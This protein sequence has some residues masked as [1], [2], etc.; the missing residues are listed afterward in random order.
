MKASPARS[1]VFLAILGI[2]FSLMPRPEVALAASVIS[3]IRANNITATSATITWQ[4][5]VPST[6]QV[7]RVGNLYEPLG[8]YP[9]PYNPQLVTQH[10]VVMPNLKPNSDYLFYVVSKDAAGTI[11]SS[12]RVRPGLIATEPDSISTF[13]TLAINTA[14]ALDYRLDI[15]GPKNVYA[16]SDLY[17]RIETVTT[18]G[19][20][21]NPVVHFFPAKQVSGLPATI[22]YTV[23]CGNFLDINTEPAG[24][25]SL[26]C[27]SS[28]NDAST[29]RFKVSANTPPGTYTAQVKTAAVASTSAT[30]PSLKEV[31]FTYTFN[32]LPAPAA[33]AKTAI[34]S[35]PPIPG[36]AKWE[37]QMLTLGQ[38]WCQFNDIYGVSYEGDV[39]Y[40][41]GGRVY[42]QIADY[43]KDYNK[44]IPCAEQVLLQYR[45]NILG[46]DMP[47]GWRRFPF[48]L[49]MHY[50]RYGDQKDKDALMAL[51]KL[52]DSP[53]LNSVRTSSGFLVY[54]YY[55]RELSYAIDILVAGEQVGF[56]PSQF[57]GRAVD[58]ALAMYDQLFVSDKYKFHH[59]FMDG[60]MAEALISYYE[61]TKDPRIPP[62]IKQ[63]L[64]WNWNSAWDQQLYRMPY[65]YVHVPPE[66]DNTLNNLIVPAYAWYWQLTGDDT[67]RVRG[68]EIFLHALD[69]D[70]S[71]TGKVFSQ[72]YKWSFDYVRWRSGNKL[73]AIQPAA[74]P[75]MAPISPPVGVPPAVVMYSGSPTAGSTVS[76]NAVTVAA[77]AFDL[78]GIAEVKF[79]ANA[80]LI[81]ASSLNVWPYSVSWNTTAL[82]NG[83][84]NVYAVAKDT[85]GN[86][87]NSS[88]VTVQVN[89][90]GAPT[91]Q[92][93]TFPPAVSG[94]STSVTSS[95]AVISWV[96]N[97]PSDSQVEYGQS[98]SYGITS[99]LGDTGSSMTTNHS[100]ILPSLLSGVTYYFRIKSRDQIGN[101]AVSSQQVF[102][103]TAASSSVPVP[104]SGLV[105]F[106]KFDEGSGSVAADSSGNNNS[107]KLTNVTWA[108][109]RLGK[110]AVFNGSDSV[111]NLGVGTTTL[112]NL[113]NAFTISAWVKPAAVSRQT[114]FSTGNSGQ[115]VIFGMASN[116]SLE[117]YYPAVNVAATRTGLFS[118]GNWYHVTYTRSGSGA[119]THAYYING[120]LE[121]LTINTANDFGNTSVSKLLGSRSTSPSLVFNGIMD[122]VKIFNRSLTAQEVVAE[123]A[124]VGVSTP[125]AGLQRKIVVTLEGASQKVLS[126]TLSFINASTRAVITSQAFTTD[127][128]GQYTFTVPSGLPSAVS[129]KVSIPAYLSRVVSNPDLSSSSVLT[130]VV[131]QLLAGD[132]NNDGII[133]SLDYSILNR[134]WNQTANITANDINKDGIINSLDYAVLSKNWAQSG[135]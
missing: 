41:D 110:A 57:L 135:E 85:A 132:F 63:M 125:V 24:T 77:R 75:A 47:S 128:S 55:I 72:N 84:Y 93:D 36:L 14:A 111:A 69:D 81:G 94:I 3:N 88:V 26:Y 86:A 61:H 51:Y 99:P 46:N 76:G 124:R 64:D 127:A 5:D 133:N 131:P 70:I 11:A 97:E 66:Y 43:T 54:P 34:T 33:P 134:S 89:N 44:W 74:N 19:N 73:S 101:I 48:G 29:G 6:S 121:T 59:T 100:M 83:T 4:T 42:L 21:T 65:D 129:I 104:T 13:T 92:P 25:P 27:H 20:V 39:W 118:P 31:E 130:I 60:L 82:P 9:E 1:L 117:T 91:S 23:I 108:D 22:A 35:Y 90:V 50:W 30:A 87:A 105:G 80:N 112:G 79:Y 120:V 68:D 28:M 53:S 2:I 116:G 45:Q 122:E 49:A 52:V 103:T 7:V 71:F 96:T 16:G 40:Y 56:A 18:S 12:R 102:T 62:T 115:G 123:Y 98:T 8:R 95:S 106:W 37:S 78:S 119:N 67:Y 126:G 114:I 15:I 107:A 10:S 38:K 32:V 17:F 58:G 109:G 113:G